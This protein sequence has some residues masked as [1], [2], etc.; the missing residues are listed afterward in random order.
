MNRKQQK[1]NRYHS[2]S[3]DHL[4]F[5]HFN[6]ISYGKFFKPEIASSHSLTGSVVEFFIL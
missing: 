4:S 1:D 2:A 3:G 6:E 5:K